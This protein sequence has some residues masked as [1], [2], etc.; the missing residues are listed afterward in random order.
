MIPIIIPGSVVKAASD[1]LKSLDDKV[2]GGAVQSKTGEAK[3]AA[4]EVRNHPPRVWRPA[5]CFK[6]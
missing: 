2:T 3:K 6:F 4:G 5:N 1:G